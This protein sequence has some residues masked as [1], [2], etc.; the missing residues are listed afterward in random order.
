VKFQIAFAQT[1]DTIP[2]VSLNNQILEYYVDY[3]TVQDLNNFELSLSADGISKKI[4]DLDNTIK[5]NNSWMQ[6]L[7]DLPVETSTDLDYLDQDKLNQYHAK[8]ANWQKVVYD[9]DAKRRQYNYTGLVE[10][11]HNLFPDDIRHPSISTVLQHLGYKDMDDTINQ[12]V[13]SIEDFFKILEYRVKDH[14]WVEFENPFLHQ[15]LS[16]NTANFRLSFHH[17]GRS[18]YNKFL[19]GSYIQQYN[20]ENNYNEFLGF[21]KLSL[22]PPESFDMSPEYTKWCKS[23]QREPLGQNLNFGNIPDLDKHLT[24]YRIVIYRNALK[25][26]SFSIQLT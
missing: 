10:K 18:L 25:N 2:F 15:G 17:L 13:H 7:L 14:S 19:N 9:I 3:L 11:I 1:G 26:N 24:D 12:T 20:D 21:V 4:R 22:L 5:Q 23:Q 16:Q 6:I 8:W